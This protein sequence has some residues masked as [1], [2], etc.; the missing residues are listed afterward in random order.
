MENQ[1]SLNVYTTQT[2]NS[3]PQIS[4]QWPSKFQW[5]F[6]NRIEK[7]PIICMEPQK[8]WIAKQSWE[9]RIKLEASHFLI[10][11][12][13]L[14]CKEIKPINPK[15]NQLWKCIGRTDSEAE[16]PILWPPDGK[17]QLIGKNPDPRKDWRQEEK[18]TTEDEM[19]GWHH[20]LNVDELGQTPRDDERQG[21]VYYLQ[22]MRSP[23]AGTWLLIKKDIDLFT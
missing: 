4:M 10:S 16:V 6:F 14:G 3:D 20:R 21:G 18:G 2:L 17:S 5:F 11:E 9:K 12:S 15:G 13:P 7:N 8:T 22:S 19:V 23:R 1:Y